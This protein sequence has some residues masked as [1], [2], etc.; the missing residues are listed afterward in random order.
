MA[1]TKADG[2]QQVKLL[3]SNKMNSLSESKKKVDAAYEK[4]MKVY[5][6]AL[7][8]LFTVCFVS[9]FFIIA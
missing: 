7:K 9:V 1:L 6:A 3:D 2:E 4:H 8:Q 5:N